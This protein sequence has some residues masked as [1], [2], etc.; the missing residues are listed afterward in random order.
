M[1]IMTYR[2]HKGFLELVRQLLGRAQLK[3]VIHV[4]RKNVKDSVILEYVNAWVL[5]DRT[6]HDFGR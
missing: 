2:I 5:F 4:Q 6:E 1:S 3:N